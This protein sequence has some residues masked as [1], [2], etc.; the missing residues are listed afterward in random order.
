MPFFALFIVTRQTQYRVILAVPNNARQFLTSPMQVA[1]VLSEGGNQTEEMA[2]G[3]DIM[4]TPEKPFKMAHT[5]LVTRNIVS[6]RD[7]V[8]D[9]R[10][11]PPPG[12][13]MDQNG[14]ILLA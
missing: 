3:A 9:W 10:N 7:T 4:T 1:V 14:E 6:S 2:A 13:N 8:L 5:W 12:L 11:K